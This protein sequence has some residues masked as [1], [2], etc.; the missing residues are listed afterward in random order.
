W[1]GKTN[2]YRHIGLYGYKK[3]V[4]LELT[5]LAPTPYEMAESLEQLRWLQNG[6]T[7]H[8]HETMYDSVGVDTPDDLE[9]VRDIVLR[10]TFH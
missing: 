2:Y 8:C 5:K 10:E 6:Y 3:D 1:F 7:I 9:R 4:L